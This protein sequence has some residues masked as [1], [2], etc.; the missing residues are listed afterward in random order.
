MN[1]TMDGWK[2][3]GQDVYGETSAMPFDSTTGMGGP[4]INSQKA[5]QTNKQRTQ[6]KQKC[7][8]TYASQFVCH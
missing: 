2:H 6:R 4:I 1:T 3:T 7:T 8:I 5:K